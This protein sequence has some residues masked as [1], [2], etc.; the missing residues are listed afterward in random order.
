M[1]PLAKLLPCPFCG[2]AATRGPFV[3]GTISTLSVV[4]C[5]N[6]KCGATVKSNT[7]SKAAARWNA[8][9]DGKGGN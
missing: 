4:R 3:P 6:A 5:S 7:T 1:T 8:R 9:V 2:S